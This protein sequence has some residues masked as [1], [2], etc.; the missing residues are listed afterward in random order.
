MPMPGPT[1]ET[2]PT[3]PPAHCSPV[4]GRWTTCGWDAGRAVSVISRCSE[5]GPGSSLPCSALPGAGGME[6]PRWVVALGGPCAVARL[7]QSHPSWP[8]PADAT[9]QI[10]IFMK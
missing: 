2:L 9:L 1:S 3:V 5:C 4:P 6:G 8:P 10:S 7:L